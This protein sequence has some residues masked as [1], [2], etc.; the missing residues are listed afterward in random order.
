MNDFSNIDAADTE[1]DGGVYVRPDPPQLVHGRVLHGDAD[2]YAYEVAFLDEPLSKNIEVLKE[3]I[4][5]KR[6][7]AGAE[8][9][10][11]HLTFGN[12]GGRY[13]IAK[14]REYQANRKSRD[15]LLVQRVSEL[16]NFMANYLDETTVTPMPWTDQEA[17]D[18]IT[19]AMYAG[20]VNPWWH[21]I[22]KSLCVMESID[23]DLWMV[24]G[25]HMNKDTWELEVFPSGF[26]SCELDRTG[27]QVK[28]RGKGKSFFWHQ[29]LQGDGADN[30]PGLPYFDPSIVVELGPTK[31][32]TTAKDQLRTGRNAKGK[33]LTAKQKTA[34]RARIKKQLAAVKP[35]TAGAV[36]TYE[37]LE[38]CTDDLSCFKKVMAAYNAYYGVE[39][40]EFGTWDQKT[41][42]VTAGHMLLEQARLLWMRRE[43][44]ESV[45][46][47]FEEVSKS[48]K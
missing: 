27:S 8:H 38:G 36:R 21:N 40:F 5:V 16:R 3:L 17:D 25:I 29:L 47:F 24:P 31:E 26:G 28:I 37:Y 7:M 9:I 12:K 34:T 2:T 43:H 32:L 39:P 35:K 4:Q 6:I 11:L 42:T 1:V 23:K 10:V 14:V 46:Q 13:E 41:I 20:M 45:I 30:I 33:Q 15:P 22:E 48:G 44:G 18:G 19:Q